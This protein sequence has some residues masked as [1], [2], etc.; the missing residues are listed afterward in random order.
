MAATSTLVSNSV[1]I[2]SNIGKTATGKNIV[3]KTTLSKIVTTAS[4]Q[5]LYDVAFAIGNILNFPVSAIE[6]V[7]NSLLANA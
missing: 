4:D 6:K 1:V 2:V 5:D 3:K 7:N